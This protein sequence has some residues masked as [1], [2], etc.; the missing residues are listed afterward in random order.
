MGMTF[1][2]LSKCVLCGRV[3]QEGEDL[4]GFP[5]FVSN[6]SDPLYRYSDAGLHT[7]CLEADPLGMAAT[8]FIEEEWSRKTGPGRRQCVVCGIE[9]ASYD[10]YE[11]WGYLTSA[12]EPLSKFNFTHLHKSCVPRWEARSEFVGLAKAMIASGRW[13]GDWLARV[14]SAVEKLA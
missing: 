3:L 11:G 1:L 4:H 2:G 14:V 10:E 13:K 12:P 5:A 8:R 9:P 7:A 6:E